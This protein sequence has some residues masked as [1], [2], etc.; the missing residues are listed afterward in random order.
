MAD[1]AR[2]HPDER[3]A[4]LR[5]RQLDLLD[6]ERLPELLQDCGPDVQRWEVAPAESTS[7]VPVPG[8]SYQE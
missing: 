1:A 5:L 2:D 6:D 4:R 8:S 7:S 3:L